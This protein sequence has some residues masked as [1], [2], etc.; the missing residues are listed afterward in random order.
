M[1]SIQEIGRNVF[2]MV[3]SVLL[4]I[5]VIVVVILGLLYLFKSQFTPQRIASYLFG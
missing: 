5:V 2:V 4:S 3:G 1:D